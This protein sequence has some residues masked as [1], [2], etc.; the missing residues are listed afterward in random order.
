MQRKQCPANDDR[1][2]ALAVI[3]I[4]NSLRGDDG[5]AS[6]LVA[7]LPD[8]IACLFDLG[9]HPN[10]MS[11]C[12]RG[13]RSAIIL[14]AVKT[15]KQ[16]GS[17]T[18][19]DLKELIEQKSP[20]EP[21]TCHGISLI[22]EIRLLSLQGALPC[23]MHLFGVEAGGRASLEAEDSEG[24]SEELKERLADLTHSLIELIESELGQ[25]TV[26]A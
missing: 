12:L 18:I 3:A 4:G 14:D 19:V 21:K 24:L 15:G 16:P 7:A 1:P 2:C 6:R 5:I 17:V 13:H 11:E 22:D 8:G 26:N 23:R 20:L 10:Y 9:A 25:V